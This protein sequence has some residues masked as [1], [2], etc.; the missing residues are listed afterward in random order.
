MSTTRTITL[1]STSSRAAATGIPLPDDKNDQ[2]RK[3]CHTHA[4]DVGREELVA[5]ADLEAAL[6]RVERQLPHVE[7]SHEATFV[8][9]H[10]A[11]GEHPA[12]ER[13]EY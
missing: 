4:G 10:H 11:L 2:V 7:T 12:P 13:P 6:G 1:L 9:P 5:Y 8:F 3:G